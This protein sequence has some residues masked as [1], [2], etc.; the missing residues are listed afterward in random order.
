MGSTLMDKLSVK[1]CALYRACL[2]FRSI[3]DQHGIWSRKSN[4]QVLLSAQQLD[5]NHKLSVTRLRLSAR[6]LRYAPHALLYLFDK[7]LSQN[8]QFSKC[9]AND[10]ELVRAYTDAASSMPPPSSDWQQ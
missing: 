10:L 4:T 7:H 6:V 9:V 8:I 2:G 5:V 1:L 3:Q